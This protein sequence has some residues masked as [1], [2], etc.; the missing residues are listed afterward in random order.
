M[1]EQAGRH[2]GWNGRESCCYLIGDD[3]ELFDRGSVS[4][5]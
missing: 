4:F 3:I 1:Q 2:L 5:G